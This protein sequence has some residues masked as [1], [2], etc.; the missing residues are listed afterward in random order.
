MF[1]IVKENIEEKLAELSYNDRQVSASG[2]RTTPEPQ[3]VQPIR[4]EKSIIN[5]EHVAGLDH[6]KKVVRARFYKIVK[7]CQR[8]F[9]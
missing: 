1:Q 6:V 5:W 8:E 2:S 9:M 3:I 4:S 7:Y